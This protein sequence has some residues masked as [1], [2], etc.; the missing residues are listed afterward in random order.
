[1]KS[2]EEVEE[3]EEWLEGRLAEQWEKLEECVEG[4]LAEQW[5]ELEEW[6]KVWFAKLVGRHG[7]CWVWPV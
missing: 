1:V 5:E 7:K 2:G 3:E 6:V 4:R